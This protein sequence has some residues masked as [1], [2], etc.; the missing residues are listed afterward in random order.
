MFQKTI[1]QTCRTKICFQWIGQQRVSLMHAEPGIC[2]TIIRI[3]WIDVWV[4]RPRA[5]YMDSSLHT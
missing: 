2:K 1:L 4:Y 3:I 5:I